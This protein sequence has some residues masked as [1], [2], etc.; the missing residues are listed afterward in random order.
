MWMNDL[1]INKGSWLNEKNKIMLITVV[2]M[3]MIALLIGKVNANARD[4]A[5][6]KETKKENEIK[7][8][9]LAATNKMI[10]LCYG[11]FQISSKLKVEK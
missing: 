2:V 9:R 6:A 10:D 1:Q 11:V 5:Q 8:G 7:D 3:V 4:V